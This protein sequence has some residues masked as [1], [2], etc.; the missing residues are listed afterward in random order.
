[1]D[2]VQ[3]E[4]KEGMEGGKER[5]AGRGRG[6]EEENDGKRKRKKRNTETVKNNKT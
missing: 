4:K 5:G 3:R 6:K 2:G 1:M